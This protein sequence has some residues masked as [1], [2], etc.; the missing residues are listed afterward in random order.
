L[1]ILVSPKPQNPTLVRELKGNKMSV[2]L[3]IIPTH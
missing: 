3:N 1:C 2:N